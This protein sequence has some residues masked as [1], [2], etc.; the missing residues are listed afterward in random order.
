MKVF[1]FYKIYN[2]YYF[3]DNGE[4]IYYYM[5]SEKER[6]NLGINSL[7]KCKTSPINNLFKPIPTTID[8]ISFKISPD[9]NL[10]RLI[11]GDIYGI[12]LKKTKNE[13]K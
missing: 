3:I 8:L 10:F 6:K 11:M 2:D 9:Y 5:L 1:Y 7:I 4:K 12:D 13:N